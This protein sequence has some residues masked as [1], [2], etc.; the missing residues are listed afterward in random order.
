MDSLIKPYMYDIGNLRSHHWKYWMDVYENCGYDCQYC[1]YRSGEKMGKISL[2]VTDASAVS[3]ASVD[4]MSGQGIVYLGPK[5]DVYQH[6]EKRLGKTRLTLEMFLER[7]VPTFI[8]TRG[9]LLLRDLDLF[10]A[11]A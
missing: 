2:L 7:K 5:A 11:M 10:K 6:V 9:E 8:V 3:A 1:V 4:A